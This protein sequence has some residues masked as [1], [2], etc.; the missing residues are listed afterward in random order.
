MLRLY[1]LT[2]PDSSLTVTQRITDAIRARYRG[3]QIVWAVTA[4]SPAA[5]AQQVEDTM[6]T[7]NA[8][9]VVI[10]GEWLDSR[11]PSGL[12]WQ[13]DPYDPVAL[14]IQAAMRQKK[15]IVPLLVHGA[16]MPPESALAPHL[17]GFALHQAVTLREDPW[18]QTDLH[19]VYTQL[20]T[21]L[22]WRPASWLLLSTTIG[23]IVAF[24]LTNVFLLGLGQGASG[25]NASSPL[26]AYTV[27]GILFEFVF[28]GF[29][30]VSL[31]IALV[32]ASQRKQIPWLITLIVMSLIA[33]LLIIGSFAGGSQSSSFLAAL[34]FLWQGM[35]TVLYIIFAL[36]GK[37][38]EMV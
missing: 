5:Y 13:S 21:Q 9:L 8:A 11:S 26:A 29:S 34:I 4:P 16:I 2:R 10:E 12:P 1:L 36:F 38:H 14:A 37:R 24:V 23:G 6:R 3:V 25:A 22:S 30:F 35:A 32:L 7:C 27:I 19:K 20:N 33:I 15:L 28:A 17:A 18:F 31:V